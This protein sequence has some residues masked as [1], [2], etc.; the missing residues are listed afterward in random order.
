VKRH[1][2]FTIRS[3]QLVAMALVVTWLMP[4]AFAQSQPYVDGIVDDWTTHHVIFSNPGTEEEAIKR[5]KLGEWQNIVSDTRYRMQQARRYGPFAE[6]TITRGSAPPAGQPVTGVPLPMAAQPEDGGGSVLRIHHPL[7]PLPIYHPQRQS[8]HADWS[9]QIAGGAGLTALNVYAAKFTF[10]PIASP[11]CT[12]DFVVFPTG[13]AG[14][15]TQAANIFGFNNLYA[16]TCTLAPTT[17]FAYFLG[18]GTIQ[19]SPVLSL[20]GTKVAFV[21]SVT[22]GS[23]FHVLTMDK[24]GNS[25]CPNSSPCNGTSFNGPPAVACTVNGTRSCS[26]NNAVDTKIT[27]S[28]GVSDTRS[29]P[30]VD[31]SGDIAYVGDD[32]GKLHKFTGVFMGTPAEAGSPWPVTVK[33]GVILTSPVFDQG[34]SQNIFVGGSGSNLWCITKAGVACSNASIPVGG[35]GGT[36]IIASPILD[37][38][39]Q[40]VFA[41]ADSTTN[42]V[43]VQATTSLAS[44][45]AVPIGGGRE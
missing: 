3:F 43:L 25:G 41:V 12:N 2:D 15:S 38:T 23:I 7:S 22:G 8:L 1:S 14:N 28:G 40:T 17:M 27:M 32:S 33:A 26:I 10:S 20:D 30:Y 4:S 16:G 29:A 36:P 21:E 35:V 18:T 19:T 37:S 42:A 44:R 9:V 5:G 39:N 6:S 11:S 45:V 34:T 24:R 31:Y 13:V